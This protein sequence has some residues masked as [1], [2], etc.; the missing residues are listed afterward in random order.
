MEVLDNPVKYRISEILAKRD[1]VD[2]HAVWHG[3]ETPGGPC[4]RDGCK[5]GRAVRAVK[6]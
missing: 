4:N 6:S 2:L 5:V 3:P 1:I